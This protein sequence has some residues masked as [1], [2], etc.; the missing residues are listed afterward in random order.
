VTGIEHMDSRGVRDR[1]YSMYRWT[2]QNWEGRGTYRW[3]GEGWSGVY[4]DG[5]EWEG[6]ICTDEPE[7]CSQGHICTNGLARSGYEDT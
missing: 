3:T 5:L 2:S 4:P 7:R 6:D 1:Q